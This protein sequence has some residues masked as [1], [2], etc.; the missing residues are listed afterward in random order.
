MSGT[1]KST[2]IGRLAI[3]TWEGPDDPEYSENHLWAFNEAP[4][5]LRIKAADK[6]PE[7]IEALVATAEATR[8]R[9]HDKVAAAQDLAQAVRSLSVKK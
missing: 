6:L 9:T 4:T 8:Q 7:L 3:G 5:H 2:V 1:R